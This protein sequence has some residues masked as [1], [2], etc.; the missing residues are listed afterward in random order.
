MKVIK[1]F[2][3]KVFKNDPVIIDA[4]IL[5]GDNDQS[6]ILTITYDDKSIK[7]YQTKGG[8]YWYDM[9]LNERCSEELEDQLSNIF[10][11]MAYLDETFND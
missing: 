1:D 4:S 10:V 3:K 8:E 9:A 11:K 6:G 5:L 2:F 7:H